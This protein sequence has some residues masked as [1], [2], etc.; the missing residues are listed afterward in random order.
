MPAAT[1]RCAI[2]WLCRY[3]LKIWISW[4]SQY[5]LSLIS[6]SETHI[7]YRFITQS[8][9]FH[10]AFIC[11][12]FD[13]YGQNSVSP[14]ISWI[15]H[16]I[17]NVNRNVRLLKKMLISMHSI[18]GWASFCM[19]YCIN[20]AWHGGNRPV[21]LLRCYGIPGCFDSGLQVICIVGSDISHLPLDNTHR[22][23]T[24]FRSGE[25]AGQSSRVTPWSLNQL[26][27]PLAVCQRYQSPAGKL[28]QHLHKACQQKEV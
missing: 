14:K 12:H 22:F 11:W 10:L 23:Y 6:E 19:N 26:L 25:F 9:I 8:E 21:A 18:L 24:G 13:D 5:F 3:I 7:F 17:K 27:V 16:K 20:V 15:L 1:A 28:N 4:K 2:P